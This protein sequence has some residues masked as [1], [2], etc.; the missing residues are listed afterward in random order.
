MKKRVADSKDKKFLALGIGIFVLCSFA[1]NFMNVSDSAQ[2]TGHT[3]NSFIEDMFAKWGEGS[4]DVNIAKYLLFIIVTLLIFSI[5]NITGFPESI[6]VQSVGAIL[7]SFLA[8]SYITPNEIFTILTTYTAMGITLS[9]VIPF[10][11]MV[12]A[13]AAIL[14]P[15]RKKGK[16]IRLN[17]SG[18]TPGKIIMV[19]ILWL[20]FT[21]VLI[22]KFIIGYGADKVQPSGGL[23]IVMIVVTA[24]SILITI[25]NKQFRKWIMNIGKEIKNTEYEFA[26][27]AAQH[28]KGFAESERG[29]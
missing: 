19:S 9:M 16:K 10:G 8:V 11:I 17:V 5:L 2:I 6:F 23:G 18:L 26:Q 3:T 29:D 24:L 4:L 21:A 20:L 25:F 27:Q 14:S 7:V 12:L 13:S 1:L 15:I 22:Y 28:A